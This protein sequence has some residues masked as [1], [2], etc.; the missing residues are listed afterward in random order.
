M[1]ISVVYYFCLNRKLVSYIHTFLLDMY[2]GERYKTFLDKINSCV[3]NIHYFTG[4]Q[5]GLSNQ[6]GSMN[7]LSVESTW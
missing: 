6:T 2:Y 1:L 4:L 5:T 7:T 3:V